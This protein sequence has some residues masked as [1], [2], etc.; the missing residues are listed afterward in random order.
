LFGPH[1]HQTGYVVC[2]TGKAPVK[3]TE[4]LEKALSSVESNSAFASG[5][6]RLSGTEA[7]KKYTWQYS[8][9]LRGF[10]GYYNRLAGYAHSADT[11]RKTWEHCVSLG[12]RFVQGEEAG[13]VIELVYDDDGSRRKCKGV[14]TANGKTHTSDL[15][16]CALGAHVSSL[17]GSCGRFVQARCWSVAHVQL[18][19]QE[20]NFLRGIP[21]TNVRDLGFFFEPDP[22]TRLF[23]MCPLGI[24]YTNTRGEFSVFHQLRARPSHRSLSSETTCSEIKSHRPFEHSNCF[25]RT[26]ANS[27]R[28]RGFVAT[29]RPLTAATALHPI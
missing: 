19:E 14:R 20:A 16:I 21:T 5:I 17:I 1:F 3:A 13:R 8:G 28:R 25:A 27:I 23:K 29:S 2:A 26:M 22:K 4:H 11:L 24:G 10:R 7:F 6:E 9:P 15:T 18:N 12:I